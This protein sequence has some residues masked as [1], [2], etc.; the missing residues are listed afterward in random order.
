CS[1][2]NQMVPYFPF[3]SMLRRYFDLSPDE[4]ADIAREKIARQLRGIDAQLES[5]VPFLCRMLAGSTE[6]TTNLPEDELKRA[7]LEAG[8]HPVVGES[9][10]K[11][12]VMLLEDLHWMDEPSREMLDVAVAQMGNAPVMMLVSHRPDYR[13]MWRTHAAFTQLS[14]RRLSEADV[15]AI[16]RALA[17]GPL[18]AELEQLILAKA[19]G[20]PFLAEEITRSLI[21]EGNLTSNGGGSRLTRP[22][23]EIRIPGTVQ[24]V[25]AARLDRL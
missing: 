2:W 21:E 3:V 10:R 9:R 15:T 13:P 22:V 18:P 1:T 17:D 12:V 16:M 5:S 20:S 6:A 25:I 11:P 19:E 4:P 7:T 8:A 24:E 23:E 14:L